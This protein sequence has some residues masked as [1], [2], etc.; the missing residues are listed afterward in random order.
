MEIR[1]QMRPMKPF[2]GIFLIIFACETM[3]IMSITHTQRTK[4]D[5][6]QLVLRCNVERNISTA[7]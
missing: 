6:L 2:F 1:E 7:P 5:P 3:S 4:M